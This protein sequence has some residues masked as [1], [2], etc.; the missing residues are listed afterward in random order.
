MLWCSYFAV[1]DFV[2]QKI[3]TACSL[4]YFQIISVPLVVILFRFHLPPQNL[5]KDL[6]I[7]SKCPNEDHTNHLTSK[8]TD[9]EGKLDTKLNKQ[10]TQ[11]Q[12]PFIIYLMFAFNSLFPVSANSTLLEIRRISEEKLGNL[13]K[14]GRK[15]RW[16]VGTFCSRRTEWLIYLIAQG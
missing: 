13:N 14:Y 12:S 2:F 7:M 3:N 15:D 6:S 9:P 11:S 1:N 4:N 10:S 5:E 16:L 8:Q